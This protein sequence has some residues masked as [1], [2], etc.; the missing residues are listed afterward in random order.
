MVVC[1]KQSRDPTLTKK[2]I[3]AKSST[4]NQATRRI[5][6]STSQTGIHMCLRE[7]EH[8]QSA[9]TPDESAPFRFWE[10]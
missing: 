3:Q 1:G 10:G 2:L 7:D 4:R 6:Y 8:R 9:A 5:G